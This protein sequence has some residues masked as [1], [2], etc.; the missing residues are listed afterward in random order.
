MRQIIFRE[1]PPQRRFGVELEVSNNLSKKQIGQ[2]VNDYESI[3]NTKKRLVKVTSGEEGWAQTKDNGY[4][5]VKFD[6]TCGPTGGFFDNG[7]EVAS[8]IGCGAQDVNHIS[9]LA[10]F[11]SNAGSEVNLNCGLHVHVE[12]ADFNEE[13]MGILLSNWLK[14]EEF[15]IS[16]CHPSRQNNKYCLP[17]RNKF[18][19]QSKIQIIKTPLDVW[20]CLR[21][22]D[23]NIHNNKDK[24]VTLNTVG[25]AI[26][27]IN[28]FFSR[29]TIEL[30]LPECVLD[31]NH[32]KNW[33]RLII[34]FVETS[35][36]KKYLPIDFRPAKKL[37]DI[38]IH[39]GLAECEEFT[40]LDQE[41]I[42]TKIWFLK[43]IIK[44]SQNKKVINEA[45]ELLE[46][47]TLI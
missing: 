35:K 10:R 43:Q 3:Y 15:L 1:L 47:I 16:I 42:S 14:V 12:V 27:L 46:F 11:L 26:S 33:I 36:N 7:W 20:F 45:K 9:R 39:L 4:W 38:L 8:Y 17:L 24:R 22:F 18:N 32:V 23:L 34:N 19:I 2:I 29:K 13:D 40:I 44:K 6:R 28:S 41:L 25:F 5:H 30:R 37:S 31:E 21:P